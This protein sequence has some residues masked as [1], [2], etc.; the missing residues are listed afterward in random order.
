MKI[1]ATL[2]ATLVAQV[3]PYIENND[4][5]HRMEHMI[6]VA[7]NGVRIADA[8]HLL[9]KP[10]LY[11]ALL[12]DLYS[13][14]DRTNHHVLAAEWVREN[15]PPYHQGQ[16]SGGWMVETVSLMCRHHRASGSGNYPNIY[17]EAFAAA[18][19]GPLILER[20]VRRSFQHH[21]DPVRVVTHLREKFAPNTGYASINR[22]HAEL[23]RKEN[24]QFYRELQTL[25][26]EQVVAIVGAQ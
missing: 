7:E 3:T 20:S 8:L 24:E 9:H 16:L 15:L 19:R 2:P 5:A 18:D 23:F 17:C 26:P 14:R 6:E 22:T 10:F 13:G 4:A 21:P 25:T 1:F 11:A 12:H